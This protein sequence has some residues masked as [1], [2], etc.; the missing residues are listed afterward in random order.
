MRAGACFTSATEH[1]AKV[2]DTLDNLKKLSIDVEMLMTW[3]HDV[4]ANLQDLLEASK[5]PSLV[6]D[7]T[8]K[9]AIEEK[10]AVSVRNVFCSGLIRITGFWRHKT[11]TTKQCVRNVKFLRFN[12]VGRL[13][14]RANFSK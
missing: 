13:S 6:D 3:E 2:H 10:L 7:D 5:D 14:S 9:H 1:T 4:L 8:L 11:S 12:L